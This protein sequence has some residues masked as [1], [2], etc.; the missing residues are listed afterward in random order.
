MTRL[1]P[2]PRSLVF[3]LDFAARIRRGEK[4]AELLRYY[5]V[6]R[7]TLL[8]YRRM[9]V[10]RGHLEE[11]EWLKW[12]DTE[13]GAY[14]KS[15]Q[16]GPVKRG[17]MLT[18]ATIQLTI[19]TVK[20]AGSFLKAARRL[21]IDRT[22]INFRLTLALSR[23]LLTNEQYMGLGMSRNR[24]PSRRRLKTLVADTLD[25]TMDPPVP[26]GCEDT[27]W[28]I[29]DETHDLHTEDGVTPAPPGLCPEYEI[30]VVRH[31]IDEGTIL[32][33]LRVVS[34]RPPLEGN[35]LAH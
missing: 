7:S 33:V 22:T 3:M 6:D 11:S 8:G 31:S 16:I 19:D 5:R 17:K 1:S 28:R 12:C 24:V 20:K 13:R 2:P 23:G 35:A 10:D 32:R 14:C 29:H 18:D 27:G 21:R 25:T 34:S 30:D 9:A 15:G 26:E 4:R